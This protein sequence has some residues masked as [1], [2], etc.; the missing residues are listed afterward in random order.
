MKKAA[1]SDMSQAESPSAEVL[2]RTLMDTWQSGDTSG[3]KAILHKDIVYEDV[4][5][6]HVFSGRAEV[7]GY[8]EHVHSWAADLRIEVRS[9]E[10]NSKMAVGEWTMIARQGQPIGA[11]IRVATNRR[12]RLRG[13]TLVRVSGGRIIHATDYLDAL[14]LMRQ[15]GGQVDLPGGASMGPLSVE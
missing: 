14:T 13:V 6:E 7:A 4:P 3:L 10:S 15:L 11:R 5:N 2:L 9:I 1:K 12:A 8:I